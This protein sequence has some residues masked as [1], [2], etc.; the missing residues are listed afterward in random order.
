MEFLE[1]LI[2]IGCAF[3]AGGAV[4]IIAQHFRKK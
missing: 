1:R 3:V 2:M 4:V